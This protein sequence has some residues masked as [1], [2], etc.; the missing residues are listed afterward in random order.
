MIHGAFPSWYATVIVRRSWSRKYLE[1]MTHLHLL[2]PFVCL[3][4]SEID[5]HSFSK[6]RPE[7]FTHDLYEGSWVTGLMYHRSHCHFISVKKESFFILGQKGVEGDD[8]GIS[9]TH[10]VSQPP[11]N[12]FM[13]FVLSPKLTRWI[14]FCPKTSYFT[15]P[16][17]ENNGSDQ[18]SR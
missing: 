5:G 14:E 12:D 16:K 3:S 1:R 4:C 17:A 8:Q 15:P 11:Q 7:S 9:F 18:D 2:N 10:R 6:G 13:C